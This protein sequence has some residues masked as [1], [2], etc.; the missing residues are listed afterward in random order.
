LSEHELAEFCRLSRSHPNK[1]IA[2]ITLSKQ[3]ERERSEV[4]KKAEYYSGR[5]DNG[6]ARLYQ[7]GEA[8]QEIQLF[9]AGI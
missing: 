9:G 4:R 8:I 6:M 2:V 3:F 1:C 5:I 7:N